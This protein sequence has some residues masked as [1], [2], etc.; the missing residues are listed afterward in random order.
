MSL[1]YS[2]KQLL[3]P[4]TLS[5]DQVLDLVRGCYVVNKPGET[6]KVEA[7]FNVAADVMGPSIGLANPSIKLNV[8]QET[9]DKAYLANFESPTHLLKHIACQMMQ[10]RHDEHYSF[11]HKT[12]MAILKELDAYSWCA[13]AVTALAAFALEYGNFWHLFQVPKDD[14]LGKSLAVLNHVQAF[15]RSRSD[16][17]DYNLVVKNAFLCVEYLVS[18]ERM[19]KQGYDL[20]ED[21][22]TLGKA[23]QEF[24]VF[25]YWT[26]LTIAICASYIDILL[27]Y[28]SSGHELSNISSKISTV[29]IKLKNYLAK[30]YNDEKGP[31]DEYNERY[32]V[33]FQTPTEIVQVLKCL[34]LP[35]D[36]KDPHVYHGSTGSMVSIEVF[37]QK[38]VL[39]FL[40]GLYSIEDETRL[41]KSI[42]AGLRKDPKEV[43]GFKKDE[44]KILWAPIVDYD[45]SVTGDPKD[46]KKFEELKRQM[47]W[48]VVEYS[49]IPPICKK[50]IRNGLKYQ[51]KPMVPVFNPQGHLTNKNALH[52]LFAWGD[53]AFPWG[54]D[55]DLHL[56][57][58]WNW[59][60]TEMKRHNPEID[61]WIKEEAYVIVCG[62]TDV[63]Y[64]Y[65]Q[66]LQN[67]P[68]LLEKVKRDEVT[69]RSDVII[70]YYHH[71]KGK[72]E[73]RIVN[74]FWAYLENL[75]DSM[76]K[77]TTIDPS[78]EQVKA[79]LGLR[80]E[81]AGWVLLSKG[82]NVK[83]LCRGDTFYQTLKEFDSW[84]LNIENDPGFDVSFT[85]HYEIVFS[86][87]P[88]HANCLRLDIKYHVSDI[89]SP[90]RCMCGRTM[91][92]ELVRYVCCHGNKEEAADASD[93]DVTVRK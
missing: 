93:G 59:F 84:K 73:L 3:R 79:F 72:D 14:N 86:Q 87:L 81:Q 10:T 49:I 85:K 36:L 39:L 45:S 41:L 1:E 89:Y 57:M 35:K 78:F 82:S 7:L 75:F 74:A 32:R 67:M 23:I 47:D 48:Y 68:E 27:G 37:R 44:F 42:H 88:P 11:A 24:P 5:D 83:L 52:M 58:E 13:K 43:Q 92:I 22:P 65:D 19:S 17:S 63:D 62:R 29:V 33:V 20:K 28:S 69:K 46:K 70:H 53:P 26:V 34:L 64:S 80:H 55:D 21:I 90:I 38:H 40:S 51:N 54:E 71:G 56:N 31:V 61:Q 6:F 8:A 2:Q 66:L 76:R 4:L 50:L 15:E 9:K 77:K 91:D 12:T 30:I 25:V 16:I 18:M 60:W